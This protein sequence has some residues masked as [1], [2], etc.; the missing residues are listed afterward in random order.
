MNRKA[1][2]KETFK[3]GCKCH[4]EHQNPIPHG[5]AAFF[6]TLSYH[7]WKTSMDINFLTMLLNYKNVNGYMET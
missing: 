7:A 6:S 3:V 5:S 1:S 2:K 4:E